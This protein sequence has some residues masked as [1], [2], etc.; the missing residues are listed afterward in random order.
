MAK[1]LY[2]KEMVI[3]GRRVTGVVAVTARCMAAIS[4]DAGSVRYGDDLR[5]VSPFERSFER[6]RKYDPKFFWGY[7]EYIIRGWHI[8]S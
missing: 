2:P 5:A 6:R 8:R 7:W 4:I 1:A 3:N